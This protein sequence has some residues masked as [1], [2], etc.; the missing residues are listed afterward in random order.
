MSQLAG[1][2][3]RDEGNL[4]EENPA[5]V[6]TAGFS[7]DDL[8]MGQTRWK[9]SLRLLVPRSVAELFSMWKFAIPW[10][11]DFGIG[12]KNCFESGL[13]IFPFFTTAGPGA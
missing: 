1:K 7:L 10:S 4:C 2:T 11:C 12:T 6:T 5:G 3:G 9:R 13:R 8:P